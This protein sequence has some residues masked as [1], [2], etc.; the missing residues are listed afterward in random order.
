MKK[1]G[2]VLAF[3]ALA[4]AIGIGAG[5]YFTHNNGGGATGSAITAEEAES[6]ALKDA[7]VTAKEA[8]GMRTHSDRDDGRN[9]FDVQFAVKDGQSTTLY[10]YDIDAKSGTVISKEKEQK[11]GAVAQQ[12][13]NTTTQTPN[14][15]AAGEIT[16]D[17]AK[18]IA[19]QHAGV[20]EG[21]TLYVDVE[22]DREG[23]GNEWSVDFETTTT[24]YD[25]EISA[26]DGSILKSS[27]EPRG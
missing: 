2:M 23:T 12:N 20:N 8:T 15:Q 26:A 5:F 21:D 7:G 4:A 25:Y 14:Q 6:I 22:Y 24:E 13:T 19:L 17:E 9:Y 18:Q 27:N 10:E 16:A 3:V 1:F 11:G